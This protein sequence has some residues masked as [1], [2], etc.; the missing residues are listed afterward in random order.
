ML[1]VQCNIE[2]YESLVIKV[3]KSLEGIETAL[4]EESKNLPGARSQL[5]QKLQIVTVSI[6]ALFQ[7]FILL[8]L[9]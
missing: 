3:Q 4:T 2:T 5:K 1:K 8:V 6:C 7:H 9:Q